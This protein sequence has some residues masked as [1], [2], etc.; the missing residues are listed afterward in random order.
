MDFDDLLLNTFLLL[1]DNQEVCQ[2]YMDRFDYILVDEYQDTNMAQHRILSLLTNPNSRICV[3]GDDAQSIY[4]FRGADITNIL[5]FK[6]QYPTAR[7]IKL[8]CNYRST[9]TIVEAANCIIRN[10]VGQIPKK[11]YSQGEVGNP[12]EVFNAQTDKEEAHKLWRT[13]QNCYAK[14]DSRTVILQCFIA[15]M[16]KVV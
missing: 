5:N 12:I 3:V 15:P 11:V 8:E 10:N 9:Q 1:R 16:H 2:R 4:G 6:E 7:L 13:S 14:R